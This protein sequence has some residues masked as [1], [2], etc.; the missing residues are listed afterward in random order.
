MISD[1]VRKIAD[2]DVSKINLLIAHANVNIAVAI[3]EPALVIT[4]HTAFGGHVGLLGRRRGEGR[5]GPRAKSDVFVCR[6]ESQARL[7]EAKIQLTL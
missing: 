7:E 5:Q 4:A 6:V 2:A 3:T 1:L